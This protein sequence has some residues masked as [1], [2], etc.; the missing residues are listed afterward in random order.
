MQIV[1]PSILSCDFLNLASDLKPL[2]GE[3]NLWIH[4]DIMD[5]HFVPNLSFGRPIIEGV[6]EH[7]SLPLDAHLMV[8]NP[9]FHIENLV[10]L[11]LHNI[12]FH[13]EAVDN[14]LEAVTLAKKH[15]ESVGIALKPKT[16]FRSLSPDLLESIDLLLVMSVEPGLGGQQF[17]PSSLESVRQAQAQREKKQYSYQIQIDGGINKETAPRALAAGCDN[18]VAGSYIFNGPSTDYKRKVQSLRAKA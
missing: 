6:K 16:P 2:E 14:A 18:L 13:Y 1:S 17:M 10:S 3:K 4:L 7:T 5:G 11:D 8:S 15:Y 12:T 9:L